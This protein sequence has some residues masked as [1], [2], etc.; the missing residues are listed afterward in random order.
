MVRML[1]FSS[2]TASLLTL[3]TGVS[4]IRNSIYVISNA[5]TASLGLFG[6]TPVGAQRA[7]ECIP[8]VF[9]RMNIGLI[10][11]CTPDFLT[12]DC[13]ASIR[14]VEPLA[15]SLGL[16]IDTSCGL[17]DD[18]DEECLPTLLENFALSSS[19]AILISWD[20]GLMEEL[21]EMLGVEID[22]GEEDGGTGT[23]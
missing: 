6:L 16:D 10:V 8:Q 1:S 18:S 22:M 23:Q 7:S 20:L 21:Y 19:R 3:S 12:G 17:D 5:E 11:S 4:A 13:Y 14:T 2:L 15:A 9:S